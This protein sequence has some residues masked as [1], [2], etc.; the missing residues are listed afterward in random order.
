MEGSKVNAFVRVSGPPNRNYL[1]G[2]P[3]ISAT[4]PRIEGK[5]EIR[6]GAGY[7]APVGISYVAIG[8]YRKETIHPHAD[9]I[10][11]NHLAAPRKEIKDLVG[12][13][14]RLFQCSAGK[15]YDSV[16]AMDLPFVL[17]IPFSKAGNEDII[18][19]PPASLQL[20]S[21]VAE[22]YYELVVSVQQGSA[23]LKKHSFPVPL[24]RYDTLSSFGM[25]NRPETQERVSDHLVTLSM[26]LQRWSFGPND[27]VEVRVQ[28]TPNP[29]WMSKAKKVS[30]QRLVVV[31]EEQITY[32]P[33]GDEPTTKVNKLIT[34]KELVGQKLPPDGY[35]SD[36]TIRFPAKELRD[37]DGFLPPPKPAFPMH[38]IVGF[39]TTATLYKIDYFLSVKAHMSSCRDI[40]LRQRIIVSPFDH[41]TCLDEL[42]SIMQAA[43]DATGINGAG[44]ML[45]APT[46]VRPGDLNALHWL[47]MTMVGN[48]RKLLIH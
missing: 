44:P 2:Y 19:V 16:L 20:P 10:I 29:D 13:E 21:R 3:G 48:E 22:T 23:D 35:Q 25:Y 9:S 18:K 17:F 7:S 4:L 30:I 34:K 24:S 42:P 11:S 5:V 6:P 14:I 15:A 41:Q 28:L 36:I 46:I 47:G 12:K 26:C 32:N 37:S 27:P 39:T 8:L 31:I 38:P 33:E 43:Q 40:T 45:P 1:V